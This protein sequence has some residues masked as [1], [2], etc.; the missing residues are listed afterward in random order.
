MAFMNK[1]NH[2]IT[3]TLHTQRVQLSGNW[4]VHPLPLDHTIPPIDC[5]LDDAFMVPDSTHLQLVLHPDKPY[6]GEHL[7]AINQQAWVYRR[8]FTV[9]VVPHQRARLQFEGVDYFASVWLNGHWLGQ[10]E[11]HFAPFSFDVT[12]LLRLNEENHLVVQVSSPWDTPNPKGSYPSDHVLRNLVKGLYEHGE[13]LI[14]PN[15]NPLGIWRPVFLL[16]DQGLSIDRMRV[17]AN[18]DGEAALCLTLT[19]A[20]DAVWSGTLRLDIIPE[21]HQQSGA[22]AQVSVHLPAGTHDIE[23]TLNVGDPGLW[24]P[25]DHGDPYLYRLTAQLVDPSECA[26]SLATETFGFRTTRLERTPE[27]FTYYINDRPV[28]IRGSSYLPDLYLSRCTSENLMRDITLA[29]DAHLNLLR[30]HVHVSPPAFYDLCD[31]M[32]MLVWQDFEL[33]WIHNSSPTFEARAR[34]LQKEM[35]AS[36]HNHP[37]II[38]WSCHNEPTMIFMRRDNLEKHPDPALYADALEQD[39]T[40]PVFICSGQ[41]EHDWKR[42]GDVHT[43]YGAIWTKQYT[44]VYRHRAR[45]Y[46]EFGFEAPAHSS[47]LQ[48]YPDCWDRLQ[49]LAGQIED[50]WAYQAELTRFHIEHIRRLRAEGCAGYVHFWLADLVPQVGCGAL[51]SNRQPKGGYEALR[52]ASQPLHIAMEYDGRRPY[53]LWI[54]NDTPISYPDLHVCWTVGDNG[55]KIVHDG[56]ILF[57]IEPN[58]SQRVMSVDWHPDAC[59]D[60]DLVLQDANGKVLTSNHYCSPFK[61]M[62]RPQGYPWKFDPYL[63]CKVFNRA[64]AHSLADQVTNPLIKL[65][66]LAVRESLIEW[67]LRQRFP[68]RL[69]QA[70]ARLTG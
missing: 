36:L 62:E 58:T 15:V 13:G 31:R 1:T 11:G 49:H 28:F 43:Y 42:A 67:G 22:S 64:D 26:L 23:H 65:I 52:R 55:G 12:G 70:V 17:R 69:V 45:L 14:P 10:H 4:Q 8:S 66:P 34:I 19:N 16:L 20:T 24:W 53:A 30:A 68:H 35:I 32:G 57:P 3:D 9:Q 41:M 33:N 47:T 48:A 25:W 60:V 50:L 51:D 5:P 59:G 39:P 2:M 46:T 37:S 54:F 40:R 6:W 61:A 29:R 27:R 44:D 21:N 56:N 63:G 7:R 18:T 38:T